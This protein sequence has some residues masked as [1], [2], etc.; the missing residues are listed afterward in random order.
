VLLDAI[1]DVTLAKTPFAGVPSGTR[2]VQLPDNQSDSYFLSVFGR[3]DGASACECERSSDANLAQALHLFNSDELLT[4]IGARAAAP[5]DPVK[6]GRGK[7][8]P[9]GPKATPGE[10]LA[11]LVADKRPHEQRLRELYLIALSREPD[12]D[13]MAALLAHIEKK[14]DVQAAYADILW[15]LLNTKEFL[16]NH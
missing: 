1:D 11:K 9:S 16:Y 7:P 2:A 12:G 4:K 3:P 5:A 8:G 10:R 6:G 14:G 15:A 13:E